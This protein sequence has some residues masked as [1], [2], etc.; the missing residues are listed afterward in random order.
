RDPVE[1]RGIGG[2]LRDLAG[3][4]H[5]DDY[6][7]VANAAQLLLSPLSELATLLA[8]SDADGPADV[9][10]ISHRDGTPSGLMLIRCGSLWCIPQVGYVDMK[11][12][13]LP[14]IA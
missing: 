13:A 9:S 1:Y 2:V 12:Q 4:Y 3:D 10:L 14:M 11:E 6:I 7:L 8:E 5:R